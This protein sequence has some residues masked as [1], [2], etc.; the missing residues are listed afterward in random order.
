MD[1]RVEFL[2]CDKTVLHQSAV[3]ESEDYRTLA[4]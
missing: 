4:L 2:M 3:D 1:A